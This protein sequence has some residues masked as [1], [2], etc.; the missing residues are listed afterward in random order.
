MLDRLIYFILVLVILLP[1]TACDNLIYDQPINPTNDPKVYLL[2]STRAV[3]S[4]VGLRSSINQDITLAE[5]SIHSLA[6]FIFDST[7]GTKLGEYFRGD[8]F[9]NGVATYAFTIELTPGKRDFY[10]V[11]N[12]STSDLQS[13]NITDRNSMDVFLNNPSRIMTNALYQ[14]AS[15]TL[16]FPMSRVYLNQ[17]ISEGG[18]IYQPI[19]FKP[20]QHTTEENKVVVNF[21][22]SGT[23]ERPYV[24]LIRVVA[25]LE[26]IL[27]NESYSVVDKIYFRNANRHFRLV[28][29]ET[30]PTD[31]FNDN[32]TNSVLTKLEG[33]NIYV[34]YMPEAIFAPQLWT[35]SG[36]NKPINYFTIKTKDNKIYDI[37]IISN[38]STITTDYL[39]KAKGTFIGFTPNYTIFRNYH[40]KYL[41]K[42]QQKIE[43]IYEVEP[44]NIVN[45]STYMGYGYNVE[46]DNN[47]DITITNT[48]DDC[49]PHKV[50]LVAKNGAYFGTPTNSTIEY[51]FNST[52][53]PNYDASKLKSGYSE[54]F[55]V[56]KDVVAVGQPY[57]EVYYNK[58]PGTG[59]TADKIFIK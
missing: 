20:K 33:A 5:D 58:V 3:Q 31:Y 29:F 27:D 28:E 21:A 44:W 23:V 9:G 2:V 47:G 35:L 12:M 39:S 25:K 32:S 49:M 48:M 42:I 54:S 14:S 4:E 59:I 51:G 13:A 1:F 38:E 15:K 50:R 57:L 10:F 46:V 41:V 52:S 19:P 37:P 24:E 17:V 53:D 7:T 8:N 45:K 34:Y 11:A 56:N 30:P 22:G 55:Q 26:V 6:M 40:Y 36:D 18:T 16:G 43:I